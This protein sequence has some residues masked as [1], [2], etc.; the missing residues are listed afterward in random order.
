M[1]RLKKRLIYSGMVTFAIATVLII[2]YAYRH[3]DADD[4]V[5]LIF[6]SYA[7]LAVLL[8]FFFVLY[9]QRVRRKR[10]ISEQKRLRHLVKN[11]TAPAMLWDD[12]LNTAELN[13]A[14]CR[15]AELDPEELPSPKQLVPQLFG[16]ELVTNLIE[17]VKELT[18]FLGIIGEKSAFT[19]F[20]RDAEHGLNLGVLA[21]V[22]IA[23]I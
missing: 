20:L 7:L 5:Y 23:E 13:E 14:L 21:S 16:M 8:S 11:L 6:N 22:E 3:R 4:L 1:K 9:W 12:D 2:M 10:R 17:L 18:P 15:A 19:I